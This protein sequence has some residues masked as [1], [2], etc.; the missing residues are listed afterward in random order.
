MRLSTRFEPDCSGACRWAARLRGAS[1]K[2][3]AIVSSTSVASI[4]ESRKRTAGTA[5]MSAS[6]SSPSEH[7]SRFPFP[8]SRSCPYVPIWTPVS[9]ISACRSAS[10]RASSISSEI[11]RERFAP[12]AMVVA[13][14]VQCS[15]QPSWILRSPRDRDVV[16]PLRMAERGTGGEES[17][18]A[19]T[20]RAGSAPPTT[21]RTCG[22]AAIVPSSRAAAQPITTVSSLLPRA[23]R[24]TKRRSLTSASCV[25][26][27][28]FTTATSA[29]AGS[30]TIVAPWSA[31]AC[32][33]RAV[34][35]W[36]ALQPNVWK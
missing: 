8:L 11:D 30:S 22:R 16:P 36:F 25:T 14:K 2:S 32:S 31:N 12:R 6:R 10:A 23:R 3:R 33:T 24:R 35:Y 21:A 4:E 5:V 27:H 29:A 9:T 19:A 34:S 17:P 18:A 1:I 13:Q 15:S 20:T 7:L 28:E 26:V